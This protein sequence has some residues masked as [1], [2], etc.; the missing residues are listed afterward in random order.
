[1]QGPTQAVGI[2]A[3]GRLD[4][5]C[6]FKA[7]HRKQINRGC[8]V[9]FD[10]NNQRVFDHAVK[11]TEVL[12]WHLNT[13]GAKDMKDKKGGP[14]SNVINLICKQSGAT[15]LTSVMVL[16]DLELARVFLTIPSAERR[17]QTAEFA[18]RV[19]ADAANT[20]A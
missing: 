9:H 11:F 3:A 10:G 16:Q 2:D 14:A 6:Q 15:P 18:K 7:Y 12:F 8:L 13:L 17:K 1:M 5:F 19:A 20:K 4:L